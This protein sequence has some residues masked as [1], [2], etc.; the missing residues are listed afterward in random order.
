MGRQ[1]VTEGVVFYLKLKPFL[2]SFLKSHLFIY[3]CSFFIFLWHLLE[4]LKF[5]N[6]FVF[7]LLI[8]KFEKKNYQY[9]IIIIKRGHANNNHNNIFV[10]FLLFFF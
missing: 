7:N 4:Y 6:L 9:F 5:L 1:R 3:F 10:L 2:L 8:N